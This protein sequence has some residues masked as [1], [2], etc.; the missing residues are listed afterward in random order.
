MMYAIRYS[1]VSALS[2]KGR[3]GAALAY[4]YP[5]IGRDAKKRQLLKVIVL[6]FCVDRLQGLRLASCAQNSSANLVLSCS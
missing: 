5:L 2:T 1:P 3:R 4:H 6:E